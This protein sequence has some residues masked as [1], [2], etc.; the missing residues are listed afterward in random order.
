MY[1]GHRG[2]DRQLFVPAANDDKGEI[3]EDFSSDRVGQA[4]TSCSSKCAG[5]RD[6]R[7][8]SA[9]QLSRAGCNIG[10]RYP[11]GTSH[12]NSGCTTSILGNT[13]STSG[14]TH[15]KASCHRSLVSRELSTGKTC[16]RCGKRRDSGT[17]EA[18]GGVLQHRRRTYRFRR[19]LAVR[20]VYL[21]IER[22][23]K[24]FH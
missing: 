13:S 4:R 5:K 22:A 10:S 15:G 20:R 9:R 3:G 19:G 7:I 11:T 16:V 1:C 17:E 24:L 21:A 2:G 23:L 8:R 12:S 18:Q 14:D 6:D